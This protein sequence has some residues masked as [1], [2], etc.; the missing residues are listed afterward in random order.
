M[1][2]K[3]NPADPT[4]S[5]TSSGKG[6]GRARQPSPTPEP[7]DNPDEPK[8]Y[9]PPDLS[10]DEFP[11]LP[12]PPPKKESKQARREHL[13]QE[14]E[15]D[16]AAFEAKRRAQQAL[17]SQEEIDRLLA[18]QPPQIELP[19]PPAP[20]A[21]SSSAS[22][23]TSLWSEN[24]E[25]YL[26]VPSHGGTSSGASSR[27]SKR[28]RSPSSSSRKDRTSSA[29][30]GHGSR[31]DTRPPPGQLRRPS[32]ELEEEI[33]NLRMELERHRDYGRQDQE[34]IRLLER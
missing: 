15:N 12:A 3:K 24:S 26:Q 6:K 21:D 20:I 23:P 14:N 19:G 27:A 30:R 9:A 32:L 22:R 34:T 28:R 1:V 31:H 18:C 16:Y 8:F 11:P 17:A 33:R 5:G 13:E 7:S 25:Q 10:D 29:S 4:R 2:P